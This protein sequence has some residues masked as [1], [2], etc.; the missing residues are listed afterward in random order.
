MYSDEVTP[1][2]QLRHQNARKIQVVYWSLADFGLQ[3]LSNER[4]WFMLGVCR[5][6]LVKQLPGKM[7][8]LMKVCRTLFLEP[9]DARGG[10]VLSFADGTKTTVFARPCFLLGDEAALKDAV[11]CKGAAGTF[12]CP[13]CANVC[14]VKSGLHLHDSRGYLVPSSCLDV[15]A[16]RGNTDASAR[17]AVEE[18]LRSRA[19][20]LAR[21]RSLC[22]EWNCC[23]FCH[24]SNRLNSR[25][26]IDD[27]RG[28][29]AEL[30]DIPPGRKE[31]LR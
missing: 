5:S 7:S 3:R 6:D 22:N 14:D 10:F 30:L 21:G 13:L 15:R 19:W 24:R 2:N 16:F 27:A 26:E 17:A 25:R 12:M 1:G 28:R 29:L 23:K 18:L 9:H 4:V 20:Q 31:L 8:E 11:D